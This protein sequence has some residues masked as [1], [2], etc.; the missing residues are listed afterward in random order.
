MFK[1]TLQSLIFVVGFAAWG[2]AAAVP[3]GYVHQVKGTVTLRDAGKPPVQA[4]AG[5][6]FEQGANFTTAAGG[7]VTLKFEDGQII[8]I[9]PNAQFIATTYSYDKAKVSNSNIVFNLVRGGMRFI[10]GAIATTDRSKFAIRTQTATI[11]VRGTVGDVIVGDNGQVTATT[12]EGVVS[13][14]VGGL[15]VSI[16]AGQVTTSVAGGAPSAPVPL[17][18]LPPALAA[19]VAIVRATTGANSPP[20]PSPVAVAAT[21]EAVRTAV[22]AAQQPNNPVAQEA[23][24]VASNNAA[25]QN[26]AAINT[27]V[28]SGAIIP[29]INAAVQATTNPAPIALPPAP[30]VVPCVPSPPGSVC[31]TP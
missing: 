6:T 31:T 15:T 11:G 16:N 21:A 23:A 19:A 29:D 8:V 10:S 18:S 9:A 3:V 17:A 26:Q 7:E 4:N 14:T 5:D 20:Q 1:K 13:F 12:A 30:L 25:A 27:A 22:I 2:L 24:R 28:A